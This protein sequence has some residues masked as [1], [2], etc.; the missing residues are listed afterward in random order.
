MPQL[1]DA[2]RV[3]R[4]EG[5][6]G[7]EIAAVVGLNP[8]R[9]PLDVWLDKTEGSRE[10]RAPQEPDR[11]GMG[12][13]L[14]PVILNAYARLTGERVHL[15]SKGLSWL[16]GSTNSHAFAT[17]DAYLEDH[18]GRGWVTRLVEAKAVG[19][20][21]RGD[22][23]AGIPDYVQCQVQWQMGCTGVP[24]CDIA[25]LLDVTAHPA[26]FTA[27]ADPDLFN[28]LR[29][30]AAR[31]WRDHVERHEPPPQGA[32]ES[33]GHYL[34]ERYPM[35]RGSVMPVAAGQ[36]AAIAEL[37]ATYRLARE[38]RDAADVAVVEAEGTIKALMGEHAYLRGPWGEVSW[39]NNATGPVQ[40]KAWLREV[41]GGT[42]PTDVPAQYRGTPARVFHLT[43]KGRIAK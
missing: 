20:R 17:P 9:S 39:R 6:G 18:S 24:A 40:Y 26:I 12:H 15:W 35:D 31:F 7:S 16:N 3:A 1:T 41:L 28:L 19:W 4:R 2:E 14:E 23:E 13:L 5:I 27:T 32:R 22:W 43:D 11:A 42:L 29:D 10:T 36:E 37:I 38:M 21:V 25:A 30:M 8:W 34:R 33:W